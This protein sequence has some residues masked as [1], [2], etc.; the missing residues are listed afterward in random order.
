VPESK[1]GHGVMENLGTVHGDV[2]SVNPDVITRKPNSDT[3]TEHNFI[4]SQF[5]IQDFLRFIPL[6]KK[7]IAEAK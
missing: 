1:L 4:N 7:K 6:K 2:E 5:L 3:G